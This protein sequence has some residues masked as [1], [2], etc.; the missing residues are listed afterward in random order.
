MWDIIKPK[1]VE[2]IFSLIN[3]ITQSFLVE[4]IPTLC[5]CGSS[6]VHIAAALNLISHHCHTK[7]SGQINTNSLFMWKQ[8]CPHWCCVNPISHHCHAKISGQINTYMKTALSTLVLFKSNISSL[9]SKEFLLYQYPLSVNKE[10]ALST[11]LLLYYV[12][13]PILLVTYVLTTKVL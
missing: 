3:I 11:L 7:I 4:S 9:S 1:F 10:T 8:H 5:Q 12:I 6:I 2:Y 13:N